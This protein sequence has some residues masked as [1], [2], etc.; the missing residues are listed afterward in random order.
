MLTTNIYSCGFRRKR[1]RDQSVSNI[2]DC[3]DCSC[4]SAGVNTWDNMLVFHKK[5]KE[6]QIENMVM[7]VIELG[8][9]L[10]S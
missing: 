9:I 1:Q 2:G 10:F 6:V 4:A 5:K 7:Y 3:G 8:L